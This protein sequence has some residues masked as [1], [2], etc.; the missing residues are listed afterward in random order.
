MK[1][2]DK[3]SL[4]GECA[5]ANLFEVRI[6]NAVS[7]V[8]RCGACG[9]AFL[10]PRPEPGEIKSIYSD[11]YFA[12]HVKQEILDSREQAAAGLMRRLGR[13]LPLRGRVLD[14]GAA[15]GAYLAAFRKAGWEVDGVEISGFAREAA[16]RIYGITMH[17]D[18]V[19]AG[20]A[21]N[22]FDLI[23]MNQV[24]EHLAEFSG[25]LDEARRVLKPGGVL[26]LSTPNFG[27]PAARSRKSTWSALKPEEHLTFF[28]PRTIRRCLAKS[29]FRIVHLD[30]MQAAI[31]TAHFKKLFGAGKASAISSFANRFFP[32]LK[33]SVRDLLGLLYPGDN[34][35]VIARKAH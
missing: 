18:L 34:I 32:K 14:I 16:Q 26:F 10:D 3:C 33:R 9:L 2:V 6:R 11:A 5:F 4:C 13:Y 17:P 22:S 27:S 20:F 1:S 15:T 30:T 35:D 24:I 25:L 19:S 23:M 8:V 28:T 7:H 31:T 29:R 21:D 12:D